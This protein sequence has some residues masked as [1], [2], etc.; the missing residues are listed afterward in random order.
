MESQAGAT[1]Q[2]LTKALI[3]DFQVPMSSLD[4]QREVVL[5]IRERFENTVKIERVLNQTLIAINKLSE[6]I[7][8]R[9][10]SGEL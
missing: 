8:H 3:G 10:F 6:V 7:L 4:K 9:A 5:T 2:A 1:R